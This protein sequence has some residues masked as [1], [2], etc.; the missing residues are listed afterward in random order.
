MSRYA[1][2]GTVRALNATMYTDIKYPTSKGYTVI[3]PPCRG[4]PR[5]INDILNPFCGSVKSCLDIL[6]ILA[7]YT[8][9]STFYC[10][11]LLIECGC[12]DLIDIL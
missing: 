10:L 11:F 1:L 5:S 4:V 7:L 2:H 3:S 8:K 6:L 12:M 9:E